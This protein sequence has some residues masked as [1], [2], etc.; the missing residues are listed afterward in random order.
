MSISGQNLAALVCLAAI[1]SLLLSMFA[2]TLYMAGEALLVAVRAEHTKQ[3]RSGSEFRSTNSNNGFGRYGQDQKQQHQQDKQHQ[4]AKRLSRL[5]ARGWKALAL[6]L[7]SAAM[8]AGAL[9]NFCS[10][11]LNTTSGDTTTCNI[12]AA[13]GALFAIGLS[14]FTAPVFIDRPRNDDQQPIVFGTPARARRP[15]SRPHA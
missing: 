5:M 11:S 10:T 14:L 8:T 15:A 3:K 12:V 2:G 9:Y 4:V 6:S 1:F 13:V 7:V